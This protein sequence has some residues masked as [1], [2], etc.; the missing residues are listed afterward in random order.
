M[1]FLWSYLILQGFVLSQD[2]GK[3]F[4]RLYTSTASEPWEYHT[5]E[6]TVMDVLYSEHPPWIRIHTHTLTHTHTDLSRWLIMKMTSV[7]S[8][9]GRISS[10]PAPN[11]LWYQVV[12]R[13]LSPGGITVLGNIL[14]NC[15]LDQTA[16][17]P[18]HPWV[19]ATIIS[20]SET[21]S[22]LFQN[23]CSS[24]LCH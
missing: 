2:H 19:D 11:L 1:T 4:Q 24:D 7:A 23:L 3:K 15:D 18:Y 17:C 6:L 21:V 13:K 9:S 5:S 20:L 16:T 12:R 8:G 14:V 10:L 22:P